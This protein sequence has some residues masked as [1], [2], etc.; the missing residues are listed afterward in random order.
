MIFHI[1]IF[2]HTKF[3]FVRRGKSEVMEEVGRSL[4]T[5]HKS[6]LYPG[7]GRANSDETALFRTM[8]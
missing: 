4:S 8:L 5:A 2:A 7:L 3:G 6:F 1:K